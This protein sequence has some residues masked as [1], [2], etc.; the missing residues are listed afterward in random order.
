MRRIWFAPAVAAAALTIAVAGAVAHG[1]DGDGDIKDHQ[2]FRE[3]ALK[4]YEGATR[5]A[6]PGT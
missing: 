4:V 5:A 1:D 6:R 3:Q 2:H